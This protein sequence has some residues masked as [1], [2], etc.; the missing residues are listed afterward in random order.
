MSGLEAS[1]RSR[2][3]FIDG[4]AEV[5]TDMGTGKPMNTR[6]IFNMTDTR[7]RITFTEAAKVTS[8]SGIFMPHLA[9]QPDDS[10][11]LMVVNATSTAA[12][13]YYLNGGVIRESLDDDYPIIFVPV[14]VPLERLRIIDEGVY[15]LTVDFIAYRGATAAGSNAVSGIIGGQ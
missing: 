15:I 3:K 13:D 10:G 1:L 9:S 8:L 12:A 2:Q 7:K 6:T 14:N 4:A 11:V 5:Y